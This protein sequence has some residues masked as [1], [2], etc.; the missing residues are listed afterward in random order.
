MTVNLP[1]SGLGFAV[2]PMVRVPREANAGELETYR[3]AVGDIAQP[4]DGPCLHPRRRRPDARHAALRARQPHHVRHLDQGLPRRH[5]LG[6]APQPAVVGTAR[7]QRQGGPSAASGTARLPER[8]TATGPP[9]LVSCWPASGN[10]GGAAADFGVGGGAPEPVV[11][12]H[13]RNRDVGRTRPP[14]RWPA[15]DPS[16]CPARRCRD[17]CT[18][19]SSIGS[20]IRRSLPS[21]RSGPT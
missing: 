15:H 2:G 5:R 4:G 10:H 18:A 21:R 8:F 7:T 1:F 20:P 9:C 19:F 14:A 6:R 12:A 17:T 3:Q 11:S 13:D 16:V